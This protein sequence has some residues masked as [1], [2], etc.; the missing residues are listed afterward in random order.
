MGLLSRN[1][2]LRPDTLRS[3]TKRPQGKERNH[4]IPL[5]SV[6]MPRELFHLGAGLPPRCPHRMSWWDLCP[7]P[8][9]SMPV[10]NCPSARLTYLW[11]FRCPLLNACAPR[12]PK[13]T[14]YSCCAQ[15]SLPPSHFPTPLNRH[16]VTVSP[17]PRV[18]S[19]PRFLFPFLRD[20]CTPGPCSSR[21]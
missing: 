13:P 20:D 8:S 12:T 16:G 1:G 18:A 21:P 2:H 11:D 9:P 17:P 7:L 10:P 3:I 19:P 15:P 14:I 6:V 4:D 5:P